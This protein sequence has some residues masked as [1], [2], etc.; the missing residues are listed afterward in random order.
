MIKFEKNITKLTNLKIHPNNY[1]LVYDENPDNENKIISLNTQID[2]LKGNISNLTNEIVKR[3]KDIAKLQT[4]LKSASNQFKSGGIELT[5]T[6][7]NG[8]VETFMIDK[9][10]NLSKNFKVY[11][12]LSPDSKELIL[13]ELLVSIIQ[14]IRDKYKKSVIITSGYRTQAFNDSL[15]GSIKNSEHI[16]GKAID[17]Q[18]QGINKNDV[19]KYAKTI[20]NVVY[21]YTNETNMKKAVHINI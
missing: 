13:S 9:N 11:E 3:D 20:P 18:V 14:N 8:K 12:F 1:V 2:I 21:A 10:E 16:K 19:L 7:L 15:K 6:R 17:F 5:Y 4:S